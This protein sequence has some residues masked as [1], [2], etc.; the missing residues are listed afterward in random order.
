MNFYRYRLSIF[1]NVDNA[2]DGVFKGS[3]IARSEFNFLK[4]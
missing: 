3:R 2:G 4:S 1:I